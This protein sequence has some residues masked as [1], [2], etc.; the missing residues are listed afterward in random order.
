[1][2]KR[3]EIPGKGQGNVPYRVDI[4]DAQW[5]GGVTTLDGD[6]ESQYILTGAA[7]V[8]DWTQVVW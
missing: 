5:S 4:Y 8:K 3:F 7:P 2:A 6:G 1:M